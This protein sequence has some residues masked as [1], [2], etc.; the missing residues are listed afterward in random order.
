MINLLIIILCPFIL[1]PIITII[2]KLAIIIII[3]IL[4]FI[5]F[6]KVIVMVIVFLWFIIH[7]YFDL[8]LIYI[9]L[10]DI[11]ALYCGLFCCIFLIKGIF[12][13]N[14]FQP[15]IINIIIYIAVV[16]ISIPSIYCSP[17]IFYLCFASLFLYS[18]FY[19]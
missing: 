13:L 11:L 15:S 6:L 16:T 4:T 7:K 10:L 19:L 18:L 9:L 12:V 17:V 3:N 14:S 2:A 8:I 5:T 1:F